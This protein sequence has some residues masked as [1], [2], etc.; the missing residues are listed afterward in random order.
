[1]SG[2]GL[3]MQ[4]KQLMIIGAVI[5]L[6]LVVGG[7]FTY[8]KM[9]SK[10]ATTAVDPKSTKKRIVEPVNVI[11]VD[12]RPVVYI[13]PNPDG[14]NIEIVVESVKKEATK[15][16]FELEY[17]TE[18]LVQGA[19]GEIEL[20]TLP[21]LKKWLLGSCSA[22]G[23]CSYH[24]NV[25]GGSL[26]TRFVGPE[27]YALKHDWRYEENKTKA[28]TFASKDSKFQITA[29]DFTKVSV[30]VVTNSP[31]YPEGLKGTPVSDPYAFHPATAVSG[32]AKVTIRA[33]EEAT[34]IMAW[35]GK[36]WQELKGTVTDKTVT[37]EGPV[38]QLYIAVKK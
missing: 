22:G 27:N 19:Q 1:M 32:T 33:T 14:R 3:T 11:P 18:N 26:K 30:A 35:D 31:G 9:S 17:F 23:A 36:T 10:K 34:A 2:E 25:T 20:G 5:L 29:K 21:A 37:A 28:D 7:G 6:L 12:K 38:A 8:W 4:K 13:T 15:A 16:E 24:T